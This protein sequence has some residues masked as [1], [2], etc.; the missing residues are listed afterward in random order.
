VTVHD[1]RRDIRW[2]P[3][4]PKWK[5]RRLYEHV[6]RG[7]WDDELIDDVGMTVYIR[8]RDIVNI[9]RALREGK[10]T[11]PRC[12]AR[13][14]ETLIN[15]IRRKD[16]GPLRCAVCDWSMTWRDYHRTFKR[17]QLNPG[18]AVAA[19]R[20]FLSE[21]ASAR[22]AQ[23]KVLAIDRVIHEFHYSLRQEPGRPTRAAGVNLISGKLGDVVA[24]LDAV[25]GFAL[26]EEM[27]ET[28]RGWRSRLRATYW[29]DH[30]EAE[31]EGG[32]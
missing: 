8:C 27:R 25:S 28:R 23:A 3:R 12:D 13:G 5:L 7:L 30:L 32:G 2:S 6:A 18:G 14:R 21:F 15:R 16:A 1:S 26:P 4:V 19:F 10:V 20:R 31:G 17:R 11:C 24:F 22:S 29:P 9:H